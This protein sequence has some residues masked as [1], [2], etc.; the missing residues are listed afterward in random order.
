[1]ST[2]TANIFVRKNKENC[3]VSITIDTSQI[4]SL[5]DSEKGELKQDIVK[6]C[7][8]FAHILRRLCLG[9]YVEHD[10][11][12]LLSELE[13]IVSRLESI[14]ELDN[15]SKGHGLQLGSNIGGAW[16]K[17]QDQRKREERDR[18]LTPEDKRIREIFNFISEMDFVERDKKR[19]NQIRLQL[20]ERTDDKDAEGSLSD[21]WR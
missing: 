2:K 20:A 21:K 10:A 9:A 7:V 1:M 4:D 16:D 3:V 14:V 11:L 18:Q 17:L 15:E 6:A 5:I 12:N 8:N 13:S 19:L